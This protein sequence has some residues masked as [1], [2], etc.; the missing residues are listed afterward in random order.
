VYSTCSLE[1]EENG[2]GVRQWL[3][4]IPDFE[5]EDER[6]IFPVEHGTDGAYVVRL[7]RSAS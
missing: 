3:G 6:F 4:T 5:M 1:P 2:A 7:R